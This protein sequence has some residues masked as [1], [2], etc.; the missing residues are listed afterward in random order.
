MTNLNQSLVPTGFQPDS[1]AG[2]AVLN[3]WESG[4]FDARK[5]P[6]RGEYDGSGI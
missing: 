2:L 1:G 5:M 4:V 6:G 3:P